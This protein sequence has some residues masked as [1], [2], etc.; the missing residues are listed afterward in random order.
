MSESIEN[1][2]HPLSLTIFVIFQP[3]DTADN[4]P[5][6]PEP[7]KFKKKLAQTPDIELISPVVP[8]E[9]GSA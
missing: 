6:A 7:S 2:S 4:T 9:N 5:H 1:S 8:L 3:S